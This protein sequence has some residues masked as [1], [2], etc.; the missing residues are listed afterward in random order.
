[1]NQSILFIGIAPELACTIVR[2]DTSR[3]T[4]QCAHASRTKASTKQRSVHEQRSGS[5]RFY[6][7]RIEKQS[8]RNQG[9]TPI[10]TSTNTTSSTNQ[11]HAPD[12]HLQTSD[13]P[14]THVRHPRHADTHTLRP[15]MRRVP[16]V[17]L[18]RS[19]RVCVCFGVSLRHVWTRN[20]TTS[21]QPQGS[22]ERNRCKAMHLHAAS[23]ADIDPARDARH[24][25]GGVLSNG[26]LIHNSLATLGEKSVGSQTEFPALR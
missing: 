19:A 17:P 13:L 20:R 18:R 21:D 11:R 25:P 15:A 16:H 14:N 5:T 9:D 7:A 8:E 12:A 10:G 1:M 2:F 22:I 6:T 24:P 3:G 4:Q 26:A 23:G